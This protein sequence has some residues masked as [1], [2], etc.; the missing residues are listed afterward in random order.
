MSSSHLYADIAMILI[1]TFSV[2]VGYLFFSLFSIVAE[3]IIYWAM[4]VNQMMGVGS[5]IMSRI[6]NY[7]WVRYTNLFSICTAD[8]KTTRLSYGSK[9]QQKRFHI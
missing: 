3:K 8:L 6:N 2:I 1:F 9:I 5:L 7:G 4:W